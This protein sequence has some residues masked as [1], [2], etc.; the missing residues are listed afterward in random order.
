MSKHQVILWSKFRLF[1][2]FFFFF[3]TIF[4]ISDCS[5]LSA[6]SS[7]T[8]LPLETWGQFPGVKKA[9]R[10]HPTPKCCCCFYFF[11]RHLK[12]TAVLEKYYDMVNGGPNKFY[13]DWMLHSSLFSCVSLIY[14]RL[15]FLLGF[16]VK[17]KDL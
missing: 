2:R 8:P 3:S 10:F 7:R 17:Y 13:A 11:I 1:V 9:A 6:S 4:C 16:A 12:S 5:S 14:I 15:L